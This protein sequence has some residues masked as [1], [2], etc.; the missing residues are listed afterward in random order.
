MGDR[1]RG[2]YNK[3]VV[4]RTDGTSEI[5]EKHCGCEYFVLDVNHD[6]HARAALLAYAASCEAEYPLLAADLR[7]KY[8]APAAPVAEDEATRFR[9]GEPVAES[10]EP[11]EWPND[12]AA[13][14]AD[15]IRKGLE[16]AAKHFAD[17]KPQALWSTDVD[18]RIRALLD[19][20][21]EEGKE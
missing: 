1:T 12:Y 17:M 13:G 14:V 16:M 20:Q 4:I 11:D 3:F 21:K 6:E 10:A 5:G 9:H 8:H 2:L 15:G 19:A 18:K 7:A